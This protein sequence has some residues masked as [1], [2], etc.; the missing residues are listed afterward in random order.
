VDDA[1]LDRLFSFHNN[2]QDDGTFFLGAPLLDLNET[3]LKHGLI[4]PQSSDIVE[5]GSPF[6]KVVVIRDTKKPEEY[7]ALIVSLSHRV[8]DGHTYY[9][10]YNMLSSST[11][12]CALNPVRRMHVFDEIER[13]TRKKLLAHQ[14]VLSSL[15][16][17]FTV[18][19]LKLRNHKLSLLNIVSNPE[20]I[21][22][23]KIESICSDSSTPIIS[24]NDVLVSTCFNYGKCDV[25]FMPVDFRERVSDCKKTDAGNYATSIRYFPG[26]Y[27]T[28]SMIRKS[29]VGPYYEGFTSAM[30]MAHTHSGLSF[31]G[32]KPRIMIC[33]NWSG[34]VVDTFEIE[35]SKQLVHF[36]FNAT[37]RIRDIGYDICVI[38]K[39]WSGQTAMMMYGESRV[40]EKVKAGEIALPREAL[41]LINH[42]VKKY[43]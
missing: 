32:E 39:P 18:L 36:P 13:V 15:R 30:K 10:I 40:I 37:S 1:I 16:F 17:I 7:F 43:F 14:S 3:A 42:D 23:K 25:G 26:D 24:T 27:E 21:G 9:S 33:T 6:F 20:F 5:R 12:L 41:A 35:G 4:C 8:G 19:C 38:Y 2:L 28:P 11:P 34:F 29:I 31:F 22:R